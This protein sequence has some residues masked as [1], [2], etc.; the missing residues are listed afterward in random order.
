MQRAGSVASQMLASSRAPPRGG[1][2]QQDRRRRRE[3][4]DPL[5][6][7]VHA[8]G[9][10]TLAK[11][12]SA[13]MFLEHLLA[14]RPRARIAVGRS[15]TRE[16]SSPGLR[17][18]GP[19]LPGQP[20]SGHQFL[21]ALAIGTP[22]L[23]VLDP[24][25]MFNS[26]SVVVLLLLLA[27]LGNAGLVTTNG[28]I[29][30]VPREATS[31]SNFGNAVAIDD[32]LVVVGAFYDD[33]AG[34]QA[35]AA[36]VYQLNPSG[37][38]RVDKMI[39]PEARYWWTFGAAVAADRGSFVVGAPQ[40][41]VARS[42]GAAFVYE[43]DG[44]G[45]WIETQLMPSDGG[46]S[47]Y[48]GQS[49]AISDGRVLVGARIAGGPLPDAGAVYLYERDGSGGWVETKITPSDAARYHYFG[50][51]VALDGR[52]VLATAP[53]DGGAAPGAGG[54][55]LF[56]PDGAGGWTETKFTPSDAYAGLRFGSSAAM[57]GERF[58]VGA[59]QDNHAGNQAGSAYVFAR[60]GAGWVE[61]KLTDS[62]AAS[63]SAY[64]RS[65][66]LEGDTVVVGQVGFGSSGRAFAYRQD[67]SGVW[68][69]EVF[70]DSAAGDPNS[71]FGYAVGISAGRLVVG[72][73][74][75]DDIPVPFFLPPTWISGHI[76]GT[77]VSG[78]TA[79]VSSRERLGAAHIF[80]IDMD[81]DC[82][83]DR[84]EARAGSDPD[85]PGS[86]PV[87]GVATAV[88]PR[89]CGTVESVNGP[90]ST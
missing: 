3:R 75:E 47:W 2:K 77:A 7:D 48:F 85:D 57:A 35:G 26:R 4:Q 59:S 66:D 23:V 63:R 71:H 45:G 10:H 46:G 22:A 67:A 50:A 14:Y 16:P 5:P 1:A 84:D 53:G 83:S 31:G 74:Y 65:V 15:P 76:P 27:P 12:D 90:S 17:H 61:T 54:A 13:L 82:F 88:L 81:G 19:G 49:V 58:V 79:A 43:P 38:W 18:A 89:A 44:R 25:P 80:E 60:E 40:C 78:Y 36:W 39:P 29:R 30:L 41:C 24:I 9:S 20:D 86:V 56:E 64:G 8:H 70:E 6:G 11:V 21:C 32:N 42:P 62:H 73:P 37:T 28:E 52:R 51:A 72:A 33:E 69:E 34:H 55:Y 68:N 87:A